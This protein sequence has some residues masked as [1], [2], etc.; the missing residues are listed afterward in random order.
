[1][2]IIIELPAWAWIILCVAVSFTAATRA[3]VNIMKVKHLKL[4]IKLSAKRS[5]RLADRDK[6][7]DKIKEQI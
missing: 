3:V 5:E 1:M 4:G 6:R 2:T 7:L